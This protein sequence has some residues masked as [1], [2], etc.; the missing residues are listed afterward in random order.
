MW[1]RKME[2][3]ENLPAGIQINKPLLFLLTEKL[4]RQLIL[5]KIPILLVAMV[6]CIQR[7]EKFHPPKEMQCWLHIMEQLIPLVSLPI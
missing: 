2:K 1:Q 4:F 5:S 7:R 3:L 6:T